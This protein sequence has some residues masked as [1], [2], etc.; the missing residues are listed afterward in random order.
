MTKFVFAACT[1]LPVSNSD[2]ETTLAVAEGRTVTVTCK[3]GFIL[4]GTTSQTTITLTCS[5]A[6]LGSTPACVASSSTVTTC[7]NAPSMEAACGQIDAVQCNRFPIRY[8]RGCLKKCA[9]CDK[10]LCADSTGFGVL[11]ALRR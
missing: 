9:N 5:K 3:T 7:S 10:L 4:Y 1:L 6:A 2:R 11:S 8:F